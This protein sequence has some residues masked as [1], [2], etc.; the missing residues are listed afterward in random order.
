MKAA[1]IQIGKASLT[2]KTIIKV[3]LLCGLLSSL[4]Y[5]A[6]DLLASWWYEGYSYTD[7]NYSEFQSRWI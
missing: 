6:T 5:V 2:A 3:L 7:Q 1:K 4:F